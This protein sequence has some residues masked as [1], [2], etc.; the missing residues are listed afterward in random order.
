MK[1]S[2]ELHG[3]RL[4]LL[5][6]ACLIP[7]DTLE[8]PAEQQ[9]VDLNNVL[10]WQALYDRELGATDDED[11]GKR[12]GQANGGSDTVRLTVCEHCEGL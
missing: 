9:V 6:S 8:Y 10:R 12:F 1:Y 4:F 3:I 2:E 5:V 11:R 7:G